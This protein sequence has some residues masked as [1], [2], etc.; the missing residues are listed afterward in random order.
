M[1]ARGAACRG[2]AWLQAG[3]KHVAERPSKQE[4]RRAVLIQN[5]RVGGPTE[6]LRS[7]VGGK[8][9]LR[10]L[11]LRWESGYSPLMDNCPILDEDFRVI[12]ESTLDDRKRMSL[13]KAVE[14]LSEL[15]PEE[16]VLTLRFVISRNSVGQVL[17]TPTRSVP[18]H[19]AWLA[20]NPVALRAVLAGL[21]SAAKGEVVPAPESFELYV[22][23]K[24]DD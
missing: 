3:R 11:V 14:S 7:V 4:V 13:T 10:G 22:D 8:D 1:Q 6:P 23:E 24:L 19:E 16:N 20:R 15:F 2:T 18:L 12:G 5:Q 21:E 9:R 17:L